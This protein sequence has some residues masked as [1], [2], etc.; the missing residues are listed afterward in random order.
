MN[1]C[2]RR[3]WLRSTVGGLASLSVASRL[4]AAGANERMRVAIIGRTGAGDY[5]GHEIDVAWREVSQA[6]VIAVADENAEGLSAA[7]KRLGVNRAFADYRRMLDEMKP[8]IVCIAPRWIDQHRDM[9]VACAER[10]ISM[11]MEKPFCRSLAEAD[12]IVAACERTSA[13]LALACQT[14]Y[15]PRIAIARQ[16]ISEGKL[17][18]VLEYRARGKEGARGGAMDLLVLG[19]HVFDL[20]RFFGGQ[21]EW[22]M[23]LLT[24]DGQ[25]VSKLQVVEGG[26]GLGPLAG[27]SIRATY[28]MPGDSTAYF[29]SQQGR[30]VPKNRFGL[31]ILGTEGRLEMTSGYLGEIHWLADSDWS[32]RN[33]SDKWHTIS[34][35][36][37]DTPDPTKTSGFVEGNKAAAIDLI[38]AIRSDKQPKL[39]V[40]EARAT[41]EMMHGVFESHRLQ[42]PVSFPLENRQHPLSML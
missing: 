17:G 41:L 13:K 20:I 38:E 32:A 14:H 19:P 12:E 23:A 21:A 42:K 28:G 39:N 1:S 29:V 37:I 25:A 10:G 16:L 33:S 22:C 34:N 4:R 9:A 11:Y 30:G 31:Q 36:G 7:A 6:E 40:Y 15:S 18:R 3:A 24:Q 8:D 2:T 26:E 27:D 35:T 5:G